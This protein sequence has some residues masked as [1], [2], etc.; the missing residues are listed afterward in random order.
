MFIG[1]SHA[2]SSAVW[3]ESVLVSGSERASLERPESM[4]RPASAPRPDSFVIAPSPGG[5]ELVESIDFAAS[6]ASGGKPPPF[7][8]WL[9]SAPASEA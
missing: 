4:K 9:A 5:S 3:L 2:F 8:P 1:A 6:L 7:D